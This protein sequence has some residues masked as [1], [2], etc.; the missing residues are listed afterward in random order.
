[1]NIRVT[2]PGLDSRWLIVGAMLRP[3]WTARDPFCC[4]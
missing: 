1:M 4:C 3:S 2:N